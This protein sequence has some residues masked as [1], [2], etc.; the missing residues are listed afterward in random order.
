MKN[1]FKIFTYCTDRD[2]NIFKALTSQL[3]IELLPELIPWTKDF[4]PKSFSLLQALKGIDLETYVLVCDAYDV[5]TIKNLTNE[6]LFNVIKNNFDL[7]KIIFNAEKNCYP[8]TGLINLYPNVDSSWR[9]LNA[10]IYVGKARNIINMLENLLPKMKGRMDQEIF[11]ISYV[12][13]EFNIDIDFK[14]KVFQTLVGLNNN[15]LK[16]DDDKIINNK[17]G[18]MPVLI[19]GNGNSG[20]KNFL[21]YAN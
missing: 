8:N 20:I 19:H 3:H 10:G 7:E 9:F 1:E 2:N 11:S 12:N 17:T 4:Y 18:T 13:K 16:I 15:D 5:L 21:K 6:K 14:C